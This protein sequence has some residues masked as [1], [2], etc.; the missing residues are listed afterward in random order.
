MENEL[1]Y[2]N[3]D[4]KIYLFLNS[5]I[6]SDYSITN[7][8]DEKTKTLAWNHYHKH[9]KK[10]ER[11]LYPL[12]T[13]K[14]HNGRFGNL[15]FI[16]M[17]CH[18]IALKYNLKFEYK[19][20]EKF[21]KLGVELFSGSRTFTKK[22]VQLNDENFNEYIIFSHDPC[23]ILIN[24]KLWCQTEELV[25]QLQKYW[26][27]PLYKKNIELKNNFNQR[28]NN[29]YDLFIH[30]RLG[31]LLEK[32]IDLKKYYTKCLDGSTWERAYISSDTINSDFCRELIMKYN[33]NIVEA[34]EID[35]IMFGSTCKT[36]ILSGGTFSW[37]I[38]F[39]AFYTENIYYPYIQEP[40]YGRIFESMPWK[41]IY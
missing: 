8:L 3:F 36:I 25:I 37:M 14:T 9:G 15:F 41:V 40:W 11:P 2:Q 33:L 26:S 30:V 17:V 38:G 21:Q 27:H 1:V 6:I 20:N 13:T 24:N 32:N 35:T 5:D 23:N 34:D 18:F 4:Y 29:N 7:I 28:Y 39:F 16:N 19:Y 31:D 10:E 22:F 12:N